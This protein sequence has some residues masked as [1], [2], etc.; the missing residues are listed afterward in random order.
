[1]EQGSRLSAVRLANAHAA[2]DVLE[3][4]AFNEDD[5]DKNL[6]WLATQQAAIENRLF[7]QRYPRDQQ[8]ELFLYDVTS[9]YLEGVCNALAAFGSTATASPENAKSFTACCATP[10]DVRFPSRHFLVTR[11]IPRLLARKSAKWSIALAAKA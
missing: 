2:C 3:L 9:S 10:R 5:L 7:R 6:D 4:E 11:P 1:M 8:P